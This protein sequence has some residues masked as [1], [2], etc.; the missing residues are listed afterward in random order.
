MQLGQ[1]QEIEA[2]LT[3]MG[4]KIVAIAPDKP[5]F[6]ESTIA[7]KEL[8]YEIYSDTNMSATQAFGLAWT[9]TPE[10]VAQYKTYGI[11][12]EES[13][14]EDHHMLPVP[15]VYIVGKNGKLEFSYVNP[16]HSIRIN[17]DIVLAAA[18][19]AANRNF[20]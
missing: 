13:S 7:R 17:P 19:V 5:E 9:M 15:A 4:V 8:A 16:N 12:L 18:K 1:L 10:G 3:A 11:D 14:G 20:D 2:E 6:V